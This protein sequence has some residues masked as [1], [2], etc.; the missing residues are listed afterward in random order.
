MEKFV[1]TVNA[2]D[3]TILVP[4]RLMDRQVG[5]STDTIL[6]A[7]QKTSQNQH[8]T[9]K[10]RTHI[11]EKLNNA[12][13]FNL[14]T[15]LNT[16]KVSLLWG[17]NA[18][19][20]ETMDQITSDMAQTNETSTEMTVEQNLNTTTSAQ[21]ESQSSATTKGHI[22]RPSTVSMTSSNSTSTLSDSDSE[23]SNENDSG[24]ESEGNREN[25]KSTELA[26]QCRAHLHGLHRCLEQM[27]DAALYLTARYQSDIGP[28]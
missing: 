25:D 15:M 9:N 1:K 7:E 17:K 16:V 23:I 26:R 19:E 14:Y 20:E 24:V 8:G 11:R 13:L 10:K 5:D 6:T 22:R 18:I 21:K 27:T 28:V 12:D 4:C 3:E 2:M